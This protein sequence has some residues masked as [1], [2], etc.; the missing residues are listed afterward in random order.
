MGLAL[1]ALVKQAPSHARTLKQAGAAQ[2]TGNPPAV[3][4][5][6]YVVALKETAPPVVKRNESCFFVSV[7]F[8]SS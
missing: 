2:A 3:S 4:W 1:A 8:F 5:V 6:S 7:V